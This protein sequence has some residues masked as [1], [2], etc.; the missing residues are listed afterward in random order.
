MMK[1][2]GNIGT[3]FMPMELVIGSAAKD[4]A[5]KK[6]VRRDFMMIRLLE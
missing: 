4:E 5:I 3:N 1:L 6:S 2:P